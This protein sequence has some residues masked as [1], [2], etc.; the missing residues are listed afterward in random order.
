MPN[1]YYDYYVFIEDLK[2]PPGRPGRPSSGAPLSNP[3]TAIAMPAPAAKP[4]ATVRQKNAAG[5]QRARRTD[6]QATDPHPKRPQAT[7]WARPCAGPFARVGTS[8]EQLR[9]PV[10]VPWPANPGAAGCQGASKRPRPGPCA[11]APWLRFLE[12]AGGPGV[13]IAWGQGCASV[14]RAFRARL[15]AW[16]GAWEALGARCGLQPAVRHGHAAANGST[17]SPVGT[18]MAI[19]VQKAW[20]CA[21]L[22][23]TGV[24]ASS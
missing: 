24:P 11:S 5:Q 6:P 15:R 7:P 8:C 16:E 19:H 2:E 9:W 14:R 22:Y 18:T 23:W 17:G 3:K 12:R 10:C 21:P 1:T 13:R 20:A 4:Q